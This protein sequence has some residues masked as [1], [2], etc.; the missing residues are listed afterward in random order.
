MSGDRALGVIAIVLGALVVASA[1]P[2]TTGASS[3]ADDPADPA[4]MKMGKTIYKDTC[5]RCHQ[6]NGRGL[7]GAFPP[8]SGNAKL[9]KL[10]VAVTTVKTGHSGPIHVE[11]EEYDE[12]MPAIG[13]NLSNEQLAAVLTYVRNSWGNHFGGVTAE[14]VA[15]ILSKGESPDR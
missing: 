4:L 13:A 9:G 8:L 11:G 5:S 7:P 12:T 3:R 2:T 1:G 10:D 15:E 14:E 6:P